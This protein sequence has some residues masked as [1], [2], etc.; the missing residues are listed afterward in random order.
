MKRIITVIFL[1]ILTAGLLGCGDR[2]SDVG[3]DD[4]S[5]SNSDSESDSESAGT[6]KAYTLEDV[7]AK[8]FVVHENLSVISGQDV[9]DAFVEK[10]Q[11]KAPCIVMLAFYY[12]LG[13]PSHY[14]PEYYEEIKDDYPLLFTQLLRYDGDSFTL[15]WSEDEGDYSFSYKYLKRFEEK[16]PRPTANFTHRVWYALVNDNGVTGE[17]LQWGLASSQFGDY[18]DHMVV[19]SKYT[20]K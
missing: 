12:T 11:D 8:G 13:D 18:I 10:T 17:Q 19:Y 16:S 7:I 4:G 9:W 5:N 20:Y 1:L 14:S 3:I 15:A 6:P 2:N